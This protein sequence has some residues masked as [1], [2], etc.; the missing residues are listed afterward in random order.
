M[1][2]LFHILHNQPIRYKNKFSYAVLSQN[3]NI[4]HDCSKVTLKYFVGHFCFVEVTIC[5]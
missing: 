5:Y 1:K 4:Y 2:S 3:I